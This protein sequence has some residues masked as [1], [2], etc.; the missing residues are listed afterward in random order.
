M[1]SMNNKNIPNKVENKAINPNVLEKLFLSNFQA[2]IKR[3]MTID[4]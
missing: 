4:T 1:V 3:K 2:K